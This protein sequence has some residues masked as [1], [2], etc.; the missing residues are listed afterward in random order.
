[1]LR[2]ALAFFLI[3]VIAGIFGFT[4]IEAGALEIA[5]VFFFFFLVAFVV[6]LT[7]HWTTGRRPAQPRWK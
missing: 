1:M 5:R 4:G 6:S 2:W 7:W 3:A